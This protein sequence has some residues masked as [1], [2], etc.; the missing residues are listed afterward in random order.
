MSA[1]RERFVVAAGGRAKGALGPGGAGGE[2]PGGCEAADTGPGARAGGPGPAAPPE[3]L[4]DGG[5]EGE[6]E[7]RRGKRGREG[8]GRDAAV[9]ALS[10]GWLRGG[11]GGSSWGGEEERRQRGDVVKQ[12]L[13]VRGSWDPDLSS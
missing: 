5:R 12:F 1:G 2:A 8:G 9:G 4:R 6:K 3:P 10:R 11:R 7:R 13:T